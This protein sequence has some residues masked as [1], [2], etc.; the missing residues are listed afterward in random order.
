MVQFLAMK[1]LEKLLNS[2]RTNNSLLCVGL[3]PDP[4]LMP[5]ADLFAFNKAIIDATADL[6]C[7]YKPNVAFYEAFG[8]SG[9]EAL[10]R[11]IA[12]VPTNIPVIADAKRNDI[13]NTAMAYARAV[14][15]KLGADAVTVNPYLGGDAVRPFLDYEEKGVFVLCR[16]SNPG[17]ADLQSLL[18][19]DER[20]G[21]QQRRLFEIVAGLARQWNESGNVGLV[22]GATYSADLTAIRQIC[23]DMPFLIPGVGAQAGDLASAVRLGTDA[24]GELGIINSSRQVLYASRGPDFA[25]AARG[26]ALR[27]RDEINRLRVMKGSF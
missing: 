11:T 2:S 4:R 17:A 5:L 26:A 9:W 12:Y 22:M 21:K 7:A 10:E 15:D 8:S 14:F 23:P 24:N 1:F 18:V 3:D 19:A 20:E 6:V 13:G 25:E 16:T 27:L